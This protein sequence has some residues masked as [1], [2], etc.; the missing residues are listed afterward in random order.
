MK[1]YTDA[2][3]SCDLVIKDDPDNVKAVFRRAQSNL[4]LKDFQECICDCKKAIDLEPE[5]N[6]AKA[7]LKQASTG[8]KS[9]DKKTKGFFSNMCKALG[10][11]S[12][13]EAAKTTEAKQDAAAAEKVAEKA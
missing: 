2:K 1:E 5:N 13:G 4:G 7:L 10:K 8:Q 3:K 9:E 6:D 11:G 12:A